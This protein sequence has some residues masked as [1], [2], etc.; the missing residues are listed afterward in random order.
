[1][2]M[3]RQVGLVVLAGL[4][5]LFV[6]SAPAVARESRGNAFAISALSA[7]PD[8]VSG[9]NV[10]VRVKVPRGL[11]NKM[12]IELNGE[13]V[14]S[15]FRREPRSRVSLLG[16]I[17]GLELGENTLSLYK[18]KYTW[19]K[20]WSFERGPKGWIKKPK[21]RR[22]KHKHPIAELVLTNYPITGPIIS[23]PHQEPFLCET[24]IFKLP[25]TG[26]TLGAPLDENCSIET[27]IDYYYKS[28]DGTFKPFDP[29][30][31]RPADLAET[32]TTENKTVAYIVRV[33]TGTINRAIYEMAILHDPAN[34]LPSPWNC[35]PGWNK[36]L[37]YTFG[38]GCNAC[39]HQGSFTGGVLNDF[40]LSRGYAVVSATFNVLDNNCNDVV[41]AETVMM[42]KERFIETYGLPR[43]TMGWGGS[44]G[45][46]QQHLIGQN[47]PGLL[48]GIIPAASYPDATSILPV[49]SDGRLLVNYFASNGA[50]WS[51][52]QKTAASGFATFNTAIAWHMFFAS[53]VNAM[54]AC[55]PIPDE[56][57][58]DPDS[59]RDGVRCTTFDNMV[60]ILG[61]DPETGFAR[62][63]LDN[64][65]VQYGLAALNE[66]MISVD[67][68]LDLNEKI[69]GY[70][71][72]GF[73]VPERTVAN[74]DALRISYETGRVQSGSG[75]L[76]S[77]P[78][79]DFRTYTDPLGDI[80]DRV[81]SFSTRE[82]LIAA[83]GHA[84]N[85]V[86]L[87]NVPDP[88]SEVL[89]KM[90][91]W[92][93]NLERAHGDVVAAK[94]ADLVDACWRPTGEKIEE[95]AT[96]DGQGICNDLYPSH[97]D[98]RMVAGASLLNDILKCQLRDIDMSDYTVNFTPEQEARLRNIFPDGV[99]DWSKPGVEQVPLGETFISFGPAD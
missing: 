99:C 69:G 27:R 97:M 31:P 15:A 43:Y 53:R 47:Y 12:V 93:A 30:G 6:T 54:E 83:N 82:R 29:N 10:L 63:P 94:P 77:I 64:V 80:H 38:G 56:W 72:D 2:K 35:T 26:Q 98:P 23:G 66:E 19:Q 20:N 1:M 59:N 87:T 21:Y 28:T 7:K 89:M 85:Q 55:P 24:D 9:G 5:L 42:V 16:L 74:V 50:G 8:M 73:I 37:I 88:Y 90:D 76:A 17:E 33:E 45:A 70:D 92:L 91:E 65:G 62:R 58:Y 14:T 96:Y 84:E 22:V 57:K 48:D 46:I 11:M 44:G 4:L 34:P 51:S 95:P 71:E 41:S 32:T 75:G 52:A 78:I 68:F 25:V 13:D 79:I 60:N 49:V 81:R 86:I 61:I 67:Q 39:Y 18:V 3:R 36:R 40:H